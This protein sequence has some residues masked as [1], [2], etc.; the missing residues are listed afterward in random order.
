MC[1]LDC[2]DL[3][4]E[5]AGA[6]TWSGVSDRSDS[7]GQLYRKRNSQLQ[8]VSGKAECREQD[9]RVRQRD[10]LHT[11]VPEAQMAYSACHPSSLFQG[12]HRS[13]HFIATQGE[14]PGKAMVCVYV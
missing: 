13:N 11:A 7:A 12:Y 10:T 14:Y 1:C 4:V 6:K 8:W 9:K 2:S 3:S 5:S